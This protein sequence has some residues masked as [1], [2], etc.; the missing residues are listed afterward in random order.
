M[1]IL[2]TGGT[3]FL[4]RSLLRECLSSGMNAV[5]LSHSEL[6]DKEMQAEHPEV[7]SYCMDISTNAEILDRIIDENNV[8]YI[9]HCAAMK[10]IGIC[11]NNP[12]KAIEV[13]IN[14]SRN[15]INAAKKN[16]VKNVIA[17]STDKA[18]NPSC[19]Y[20]S[21][22]LLM[23]KIMIENGFSVIQGVNFFFSSGSVLEIWDNCIKNKAPIKVNVNDT[24][25]YFVGAS[26]VAKK[27]LENL[28]TKSSYI[29]LDSCYRIKLHNLAEAFCEYHDVYKIEDY[30]S[31]SAEKIVEEIPDGIRDIHE[32]STQELKVM[33]YRHYKKGCCSVENA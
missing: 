26:D 30:I 8:E 33:L 16:K 4:G 17:V 7:K 5:V 9:V 1:T 29:S 32:P 18:I 15:I 28:D 24:V 21:T 13:N 2:I 19:V 20:G 6:R 25:R 22:K 3:G 23:E 31:I 14:G 12:T 11:E 27:I 10:H